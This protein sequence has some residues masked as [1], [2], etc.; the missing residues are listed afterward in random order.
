MSGRK[1]AKKITSKFITKQEIERYIASV[2]NLA[3]HLVQEYCVITRE[4]V[5]KD[6]EE[7]INWVAETRKPGIFICLFGKSLGWKQ[8]EGVVLGDLQKD[9]PNGYVVY[10]SVAYYVTSKTAERSLRFFLDKPENIKRL[11]KR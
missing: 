8:L 4:I 3:L 11:G 10:R 2:E 5:L 1:G 7:V 6:E 9:A